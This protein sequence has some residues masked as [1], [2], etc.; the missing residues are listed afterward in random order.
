L[1]HGKRRSLSIRRI[2]VKLDGRSNGLD[3]A[4]PWFFT[5]LVISS[6][7]WVTLDVPVGQ[8]NRRKD[9]LT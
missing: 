2:R 9:D 4:F 3:L 8:N 6:A 7:M 1:F 5:P